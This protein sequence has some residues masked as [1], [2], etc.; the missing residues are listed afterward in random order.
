MVPV[1]H[2]ETA[3]FAAGAEAQLTDQLVVVFRN[4]SLAFVELEMKAGGLLDFGVELKNPDF[5]A[6]A[7][8]AGL[9][10][11]KAET[12]KDVRPMLRPK[13][14]ISCE[15]DLSSEPA[16]ARS[17]IVDGRDRLYLERGNRNRLASGTEKSLT[18]AIAADCLWR[19]RSPHE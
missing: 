13:P 11:L 18:R 3:A 15:Y 2:E 9:L 19:I 1:R 12:A 4:N 7:Q 5:A 17:T 16:L 8:A 10:G 6:L 14:I